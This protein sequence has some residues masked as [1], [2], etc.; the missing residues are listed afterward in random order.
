MVLLDLLSPG[1]PLATQTTAGA[2]SAADRPTLERVFDYLL[3]VSVATWAVLGWMAPTAPATT[4]HWAISLLHLTVAYAIFRRAPL[5]RLGSPR[6]LA[7]SLPALV[8]AGLAF[9]LAGPLG[10]WPVFL[11]VLFLVGAALAIWTFLAMG[12]SFAVLPARRAIV[13]RGPYRLVRH[14]AYAGELVMIFACALSAHSVWSALVL[15][16][17]LPFVALRIHAEERLLSGSETYR[18]YQAEVRSRLIPC[19]W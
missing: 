10:T 19:L 2:P 8:L 15:V 17:A 14:P 9:R 3:A 16:A 7:S 11:E 6:A 5:E 1:A 18:S 4:T 12:E 13:S